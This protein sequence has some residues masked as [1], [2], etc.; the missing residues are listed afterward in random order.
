MLN[1][2][3]HADAD[4]LIRDVERVVDPI[5]SCWNGPGARAPS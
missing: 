2:Y 4:A 1:A 5:P 3:E